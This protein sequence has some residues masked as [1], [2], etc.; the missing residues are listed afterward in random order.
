[1][2]W[3][4]FRALFIFAMLTAGGV[5]PAFAEVETYRLR[6]DASLLGI[7][8][9]RADFTSRLQET[10]FEVAGRFASAGLAR[11]FDRTDGTVLAQGQLT[12]ER[13]VPARYD[14]RYKSG[15]KDEMTSIRYA[16]GQVSETIVRPK[17]KKRG[18]DWVPVSSKDM[19]GAAD[20]LSALLSPV[21]NAN[22]VCNR[23]L[24][25]F[26]GEMRADIVLSPA[27][28]GE[29][30]GRDAITCKA[31]FVPVSGYRKGRSTITFLRDKAR[32]LIAFV[33]LGANG[34][35]TPVEAWIGTKIGPVHVVARQVN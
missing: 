24:K 17:P 29:Q 21:A 7:P 2:T 9:G 18:N 8:I 14:L 15:K 23:R 20:P 4:S 16:K 22:Q 32:I 25:V 5:A 28:R 13:V 3:H 27:G 35:Y 33:P 31:R 6:Y 26:D 12:R 30:I 1:M 11:L 34:H 10:R 19:A